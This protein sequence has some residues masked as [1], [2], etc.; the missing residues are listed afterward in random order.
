MQPQL[1][2]YKRHPFLRDWWRYVDLD[3]PAPQ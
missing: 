1:V 3:Q 2:G